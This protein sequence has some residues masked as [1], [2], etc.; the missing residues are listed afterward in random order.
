MYTL[1][2]FLIFAF[3]V[4]IFANLHRLRPVGGSGSDPAAETGFVDSLF[5][6]PPGGGGGSGQSSNHPSGGYL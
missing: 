2:Y 6:F 5:V 1:V 4:L 3:N